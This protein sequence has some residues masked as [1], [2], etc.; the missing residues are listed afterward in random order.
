M[1]GDG[2]GSISIYGDHFADESFAIKHSSP[3]I[4]SIANTGRCTIDHKSMEPSSA[5]MSESNLH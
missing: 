4:L 1:S 2:T 5:A 3:G